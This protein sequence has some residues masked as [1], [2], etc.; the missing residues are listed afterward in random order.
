MPELKKLAD[1]GWLVVCQKPQEKLHSLLDRCEIRRAQVDCEL[2]EGRSLKEKFDGLQKDL[3]ILEAEEE[4]VVECRTNVEDI[5]EL[6]ENVRQG[7]S[8]LDVLEARLKECEGEVENMDKGL[9]SEELKG[10]VEI[11]E[12]VKKSISLK[13]KSLLKLQKCSEGMLKLTGD[14]EKIVEILAS[15]EL[16]KKECCSL[17][18]NDRGEA[19]ELLLGDINECLETSDNMWKVFESDWMDLEAGRKLRDELEAARK[20]GRDIY[21]DVALMRSENMRFCISYEELIADMSEIQKFLLECGNESEQQDSLEHVLEH[22]KKRQDLVSD[23]EE[24]IGETGG[25]LKVIGDVLTDSELGSCED[26][27]R[28]IREMCKKEMSRLNFEEA[29]I[30]EARQTLAL[31]DNSLERFLAEIEDTKLVAVANADDG[32]DTYSAAIE[33]AEKIEKDFE[34]QVASFNDCFDDFSC[35]DKDDVML[36]KEHAQKMI[37]ECRRSLEENAKS[38]KVTSSLKECEITIENINKVVEN[39]YQSTS[40]NEVEGLFEIALAE[41]LVCKDRVAE[42]SIGLNNL[43][44]TQSDRH[45]EGIEERTDGVSDTIYCAEQ[46]IVEVKKAFDEDMGKLKIL[47]DAVDLRKTVELGMKEFTLEVVNDDEVK[48]FVANALEMVEKADTL[49]EHI[50]S[51]TSDINEIGFA[52]IRS[53]AGKIL[54]SIEEDGKEWKYTIENVK[55][56]IDCMM[57]VEKNLAEMNEELDVLDQ[58]IASSCPPSTTFENF[59]G[60]SEY[61]DRCQLLLK[62]SENLTKDV[63]DL[64][65]R[66]EYIQSSFAPIKLKNI[67]TRL[68]GMKYKV[69]EVVRSLEDQMK[70]CKVRMD[71]LANF[72]EVKQELANDVTFESVKDRKQAETATEL[73]DLLDGVRRFRDCSDKLFILEREFASQDLWSE[74]FAERLSSELSHIRKEVELN[75]AKGNE[76]IERKSKMIE[77]QMNDMMAN[78]EICELDCEREDIGQSVSELQKD[79]VELSKVLDKSDA[80][81]QEVVMLNEF[82]PEGTE[83]QCIVGSLDSLNERANDIFDKKSTLLEQLEDIKTVMRNYEDDISNLAQQLAAMREG[84]SQNETACSLADLK[85]I[86]KDDE[87]ML[88]KIDEGFASILEDEEELVKML[89]KGEMEELLELKCEF[90]EDF[91]YWK[92][93][94]SSDYE[95][96]ERMEEDMNKISEKMAEFVDR[97]GFLRN[98]MAQESFVDKDQHKLFFLEKLQ[99]LN[100]LKEELNSIESECEDVSSAIPETEA[101]QLFEHLSLMLSSYELAADTARS[102]VEFA[103]ETQR[104]LDELERIEAMREGSDS[105]KCVE[106]SIEFEELILE[107]VNSCDVELENLRGKM[108]K[109]ANTNLNEKQLEIA[110]Q[111]VKSI[112]SSSESRHT[113]LRNLK[114][115]KEKLGSYIACKEIELDAVAKRLKE[116]KAKPRSDERVC[117]DLQQ[118]QDELKEMEA[119]FKSVALQQNRPETPRADSEITRKEEAFLDKIE[120]AQNNVAS[121]LQSSLECKERISSIMGTSETHCISL[122]KKIN[123]LTQMKRGSFEKGRENLISLKDCLDDVEK[124]YETLEVEAKLVENT[125]GEQQAIS[126]SLLQLKDIMKEAEDVMKMEEEKLLTSQKYVN[127]CK[128]QILGIDD[129]VPIGDLKIS[130]YLNLEDARQAVVD[131]LQSLVEIDSNVGGLSESINAMLNELPTAE[132][133]DIINHLEN[134]RVKIIKQ[135]HELNGK[136]EVIDGIELEVKEIQKHLNL[137]LKWI[138]LAKKAVTRKDKAAKCT[139]E[140][141]EER[142]YLVNQING[143]DDDVHYVV[144]VGNALCEK[145]PNMEKDRLQTLLESVETEWSSVKDELHEKK[146]KLDESIVERDSFIASVA[147]C[148]VRIEEAESSCTDFGEQDWENKEDAL[149]SIK[150]HM[151]SIVEDNESLREESKYLLKKLVD[152]ESESITNDLDHIRLKIDQL[153]NWITDSEEKIKKHSETV[154]KIAIKFKDI[155]GKID[156]A[157]K[158]MDDLERLDDTTIAG[159]SFLKAEKYFDSASEDLVSLRK[160]T[161]IEE[162][163]HVADDVSGLEPH[164]KFIENRLN[165][166]RK[167]SGEMRENAKKVNLRLEELSIRIAFL[168]KCIELENLTD[169]DRSLK[170]LEGNLLDLEN[171]VDSTEV[172]EKDAISENVKQLKERVQ[173]TEASLNN[174]LKRNDAD[175]QFKVND[176]TAVAKRFEERLQ[177]I[178]IKI[179][180]EVLK[181]NTLLGKLQHL[182]TTSNLLNI[183]KEDVTSELPGILLFVN[184]RNDYLPLKRR[185]LQLQEDIFDLKA[186]VEKRSGTL[187]DTNFRFANCHDSINDAKSEL[188]YIKA[189]F[190]CS[191]QKKSLQQLLEHLKALY[192]RCHGCRDACFNVLSLVR[193]LP[194]YQNER[195]EEERDEISEECRNVLA[196]LESISSRIKDQIEFVAKASKLIEACKNV[197]DITNLKSTFDKF[198]NE[199]KSSSK[200]KQFELFLQML[201]EK[202]SNI[203][204]IKFNLLPMMKSEFPLSSECQNEIAGNV[205]RLE[206]VISEVENETKKLEQLCIRDTTDHLKPC[207][208]DDYAIQEQ[209]NAIDD[210]NKMVDEVLCEQMIVDYDLTEFKDEEMDVGASLVYNGIREDVAANLESPL[211]HSQ[212]FENGGDLSKMVWFKSNGVES[213]DQKFGE[214]ED[215]PSD[216]L[217]VI[218]G[219]SSLET[220]GKVTLAKVDN[221]VVGD[222]VLSAGE[223]EIEGDFSTKLNNGK[224]GH[225]VTDDRKSQELRSILEETV[226]ERSNIAPPLRR[227]SDQSIESGLAS[228]IQADDAAEVENILSQSLSSLETGFED[229]EEVFGLMKKASNELS[230][231]DVLISSS[232]HQGC[233]SLESLLESLDTLK[234][235]ICIFTYSIS[236]LSLNI[237]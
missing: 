236:W 128:E 105:E 62:M 187:R 28:K 226:A 193:I 180:E 53:E 230:N 32:S 69:D 184:D 111:R 76:L 145:L 55:Q 16:K 151:Q 207:G 103:E 71:F 100:F 25:K 54:K 224:R 150:E 225:E 160:Q 129:K 117:E 161:K 5:S 118:L 75:E 219:S 131:E 80:L 122:R 96:I 159:D 149:K 95:R 4:K 108:E 124:E 127:E 121:T 12:V 14:V 182:E 201:R 13:R 153:R 134:V 39:V 107:K 46:K 66:K 205:E 144:S 104:V 50:R 231:V 43:E 155:R 176:V 40:L 48:S 174:I 158:I 165:N 115:E 98:E 57:K 73:S 228:L 9:P 156:D 41:V 170:E 199:M 81:R 58:H 63:S 185:F 202:L 35:K 123:E 10:V 31:F 120:C 213:A 206:V 11:M 227:P 143:L 72:N 191:L 61:H 233:E 34:V 2:A 102:E 234:V 109:E 68:D 106:E 26:S 89:S 223:I 204:Q 119:D 22:L 209:P 74:G 214:S 44:S 37:R 189:G 6:L 19:I 192:E 30:M 130:C 94:V 175:A 200:E 97:I 87:F 59:E 110:A 198:V 171:I 181:E 235:V 79:I 196:Q 173:K 113:T 172:F 47:E 70:G 126:Q 222:D 60:L 216:G 24:K 141:V 221:L 195:K 136:I 154:E 166:Y 112:K 188:D 197:E 147:S 49:D 77:D 135:R 168:D 64:I 137:N 101:L 218:S 45:F 148:L 56:K 157:S 212:V 186:T 215:V 17:L 142:D 220:H 217:Q 183:L 21:N 208:I 7:I 42:I 140:L 162:L 203:Y 65:V 86:V 229:E 1:R 78:V 29:R 237:T 99:H 132:K 88:N 82:A 18:I 163:P 85:N 211:A 3:E 67:E 93:K 114:E 179:D 116:V 92:G 91:N 178:R 38:L 152:S 20:S 8:S 210:I 84:E 52:S 146:G 36:R 23:W 27:I 139:E 138:L 83:M 133:N 194:V 232:F 177:G 125:I 90:L 169:A 167:R 33:K 15:M 164:L 51:L 190:E